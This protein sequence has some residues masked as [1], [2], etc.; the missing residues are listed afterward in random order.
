GS[1]EVAHRTPVDIPTRRV[2]LSI[3]GVAV[4][5][6]LLALWLIVDP[7]TPDLAGQVYRVN[8]F[9]QLG[10]SVWDEHWY[11]GHDLPGYSLLFPPLASLLGLRLTAGLALLASAVLGERLLRDLYGPAGRWGAVLFAAAAAGDVWIGRLAFAL[12]VAFALAAGLAVVRRRRRWAALASAACAAASPVAG[13]LLALAGV[14]VWICS[15]ASIGRED[16]RGRPLA[17]M[18]ALA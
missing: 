4:A 5:G 11:A 8:L 12:G 15:R 17:D 14:S 7:H 2:R 13:A 10:F 3:R 9:G 18:L 16:W 1:G 6:L